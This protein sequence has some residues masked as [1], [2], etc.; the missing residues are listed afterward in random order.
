MYQ[1]YNEKFNKDLIQKSYEFCITL[2]LCK[3]MLD[4]KITLSLM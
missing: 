2:K 4:T 1:F 3:N